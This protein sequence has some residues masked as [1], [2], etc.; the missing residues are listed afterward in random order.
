MAVQQQGGGLGV[1]PPILGE[2]RLAAH[3]HGLD[4]RTAEAAAK[5]RRFAA[6]ELQ[7][8]DT[9]LAEDLAHHLRIR[10]QEQRGR[11]HERR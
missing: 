8:L 1:A 11:S 4:I 9:Y 7:E 3:G 10:V 5:F 2:V 6:V